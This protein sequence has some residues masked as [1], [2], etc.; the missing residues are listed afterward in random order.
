MSIVTLQI[1]TNKD[2]NLRC[3]YCYEQEK[4]RGK[5]DIDAIRRYI[6]A[7]LEER[8][9]K[10]ES[11]HEE[12][13]N[14]TVLLEP[15]GG[16]TLM[17]PDLLDAMCE[18]VVAEAD[19]LQIQNPPRISIST[20]GTLLDR[21]DVRDFIR[22]WGR[23]LDFGISIDGTKETHDANRVDA[24]GRGSYDRAVAG[25]RWLRE[26]VCPRRISAKATFNHATVSG[27]ADGVINLI[28]LGFT[29]IAANVVFEEIWSM[30]EDYSLLEAQ[31]VR[32]ADY[33]LEH[34]LVD[35][36]HV[37]QINPPQFDLGNFRIPHYREANHCGSCSHMRCLGYDGIVYGCHRFAT[38]DDPLPI[39]HLDAGKGVVI[40]NQPLIDAVV[41]LHNHWPDECRT[42]G[43][44]QFCASCAAIPW[45]VC[46]DDPKAFL[47]RKGYCA[48]TTACMTARLYLKECLMEREKA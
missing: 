1:L 47:G 36:V 14:E 34:E 7:L 10:P 40:T 26:H 17:Y 16:E 37:H 18:H 4:A 9:V 6:T 42:C 33:L 23:F 32:V 25:Y 8:F 19:R 44:G 43:I 30:E 22:K 41:D 21:E 31:M 24:V 15:I 5:N 48:F 2:C 46:R 12:I 29:D 38:M 27:Y 28:G 3:K 20:N 11:P 45:E 39:G 35:R 13:V